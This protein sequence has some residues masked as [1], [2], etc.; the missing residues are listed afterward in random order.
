ML[1]QFF[2]QCQT[3]ITASQPPAMPQMGAPNTPQ[4]LPAPLPTSSLIPNAPG[5]Q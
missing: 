4:A 1:R 3:L 5:A 2:T